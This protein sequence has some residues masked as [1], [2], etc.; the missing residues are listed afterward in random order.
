MKSRIKLHAGA[1]VCPTYFVPGYPLGTTTRAGKRRS[2]YP[3]IDASRGPV[4][5]EDSYMPD[6]S[7][8]DDT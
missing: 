1:I 3:T 4:V 5:L 8:A 2:E 7:D 6:G